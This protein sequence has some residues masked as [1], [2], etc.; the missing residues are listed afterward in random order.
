MF[1][2]T[3]MVW[4]LFVGLLTMVGIS[5]YLIYAYIQ[6]LEMIEHLDRYTYFPDGE[7]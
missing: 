7:R 4:S 2:P 6:A 3:W 1:I 5:S